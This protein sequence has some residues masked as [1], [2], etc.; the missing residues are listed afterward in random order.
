MADTNCVTVPNGMTPGE[1]AGKL[2]KPGYI[3]GQ[4][5][6]PGDIVSGK[7]SPAVEA[8]LGEF[9]DLVDAGTVKRDLKTMKPDGTIDAPTVCPTGVATVII[10]ARSG[11]GAR[12]H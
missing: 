3:A 1:V 12:S 9:K 8:A 7:N 5:P 2:D 4:T 11:S 6:R 10:P